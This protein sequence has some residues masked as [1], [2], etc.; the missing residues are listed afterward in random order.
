[1]EWELL[2]ERKKKQGTGLRSQVEPRMGCPKEG[3]TSKRKKSGKLL[4]S[5]E[6]EDRSEKNNFQLKGGGRKR[7]NP[8]KPEW[9]KGGR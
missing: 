1:M 6:G 4:G 7:K 2:K 9:N 8:Q 5:R 3:K